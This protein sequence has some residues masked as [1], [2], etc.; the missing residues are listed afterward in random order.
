MPTHEH[1][2]EKT[3]V[4]TSISKDRKAYTHTIYDCVCVYVYRQSLQ[5][6]QQPT[7]SRKKASYCDDDAVEGKRPSLRGGSVSFASLLWVGLCLPAPSP[8]SSRLW[9][10]NGEGR[11]L[12]TWRRAKTRLPAGQQ[13]LAA[14]DTAEDDRGRRMVVRRR[15]HNECNPRWSWWLINDG[16][17]LQRKVFDFPRGGD[18]NH[19]KTD[20][21]WTCVFF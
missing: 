7:L 14:A 21:I 15:H 18:I 4:Y 12:T 17:K 19:A 16:R 6:H 9:Y 13:A 10:D 5:F 3:R 11:E 8:S 1:T 20:W 2:S